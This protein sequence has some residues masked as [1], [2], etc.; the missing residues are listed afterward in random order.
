[1]AGE[2][3]VV[4]DTRPG[5]KP[6]R[7][8][9]ADPVGNVEVRP[10]PVMQLH[11]SHRQRVAAGVDPTARHRHRALR[12]VRA[13]PPSGRRP[14]APLPPA[15]VRETHTFNT[16]LRTRVSAP[17]RRRRCDLRGLFAA[18]RP[19]CGARQ[20]FVPAYPSFACPGPRPDSGLWRPRTRGHPSPSWA[21]GLG[22]DVRPPTNAC[23]SGAASQG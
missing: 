18:S 13:A 21:D 15:T 1:M 17:T 10:A 19:V 9:V 4:S 3:A 7:S 22:G 8:S 12:E 16:M 5:V 11:R 20:R 14:H 6:N 2:E 23:A